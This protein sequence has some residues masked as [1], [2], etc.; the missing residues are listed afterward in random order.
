MQ[1]LTEKA[2]KN[3]SRKKIIYRIT[4]VICF[5]STFD[6]LETIG[7]TDYSNTQSITEY[8]RITKTHVSKQKIPL[9]WRDFCFR[10]IQVVD[11]AY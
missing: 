9:Y 5:F 7:T 4:V 8:I 6:V 1:T 2:C 10:T 3:N 11:Q